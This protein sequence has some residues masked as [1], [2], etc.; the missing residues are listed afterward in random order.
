MFKKM[1]KAEYLISKIGKGLEV[2]DKLMTPKRSRSLTL[3]AN[4]ILGFEERQN[5]GR[6]RQYLC[7]STYCPG[8]IFINKN[9][10]SIC[11]GSSDNDELFF[12]DD[13]IKRRD[14]ALKPLD[15]FIEEL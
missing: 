12:F 4:E 8:R 6:S 1:T 10:P 2:G 5:S 14:G 7:C 13:I 9:T 3:G 15:D 11:L